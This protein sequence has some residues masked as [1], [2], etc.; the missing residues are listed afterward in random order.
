MHAKVYVVTPIAKVHLV[1]PISK[2][3]LV[4]PLYTDD[5]NHSLIPTT[6]KILSPAILDLAQRLKLTS[7]ISICLSATTRNKF[8]GI[9][10]SHAGDTKDLNKFKMAAVPPFRM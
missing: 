1:T 10:S 9:P 5:I 2:V 3:H 8:G 7:N 4:T 6:C